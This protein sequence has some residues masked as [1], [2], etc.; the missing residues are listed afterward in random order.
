MTCYFCAKKAK[1]ARKK[2]CISRTIRHYIQLTQTTCIAGVNDG[3]D[4]KHRPKQRCKNA[5]NKSKKKASAINASK[6]VKPKQTT[7]NKNTA[8]KKNIFLHYFTRTSTYLRAQHRTAGLWACEPATK[9]TDVFFVFLKEA[10]KRPP[11]GVRL[12]NE[13]LAF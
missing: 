7:Q 4:A 5:H 11:R 1:S 3:L 13:N 6:P 10:R 8:R 2:Q 9:N 12:A